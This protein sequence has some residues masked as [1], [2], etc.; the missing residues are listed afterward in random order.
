MSKGALL[1][2]LTLLDCRLY[3]RR[4]G[5]LELGGS[6]IAFGMAFY[7]QRFVSQKAGLGSDVMRCS[8]FIL[9]AEAVWSRTV[10][11]KIDSNNSNRQN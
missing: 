6:C 8:A 11:N 9:V 10:F 2:L 3:L 5:L 4:G 1:A 7:L